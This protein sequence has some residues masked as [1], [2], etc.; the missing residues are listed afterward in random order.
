[1]KN[2]E[3]YHDYIKLLDGEYKEK[4]QEIDI[5]ISSSG[6]KVGNVEDIMNDILDLFI[7]A[8]EEN[9]PIENIIGNDI[10]EFCDQVIDSCKLTISEMILSYLDNIRYFILILAVSEAIFTFGDFVFD[11]VKN[12][13]L[14]NV[15]I[16]GSFISI[17]ISFVLFIIFCFIRKKLVFKYKW[18]SP[19]LD[20]TLTFIIMMGIIIMCFTMPD[21]VYKLIT[22]PRYIFIPVSFV[23]FIILNKRHKLIKEENNEESNE[24]HFGNEFYNEV[25]LTYRKQY[26]KYIKKCQKKNKEALDVKKWYNKKYKEDKI[27]SIIANIFIIFIIFCFIL[28]VVMTS[29]LLDGILFTV[30]VLA[31][32]IPIYYFLFRKGDRIK[33]E[34]YNVIKEKD[35]D[36]YDDNIFKDK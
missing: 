12:P 29:E 4:F 31:I 20:N 34:I 9:K 15:E 8:Q 16:G 11:E 25:I 5:Y 22:V 26:E 36:I 7:S 10:K 13:L 35:T 18:F 28:N 21:N 19:K 2:F 33:N 27:M 1:M 17:F 6:F 32:E 3:T 23:L 14:F 24:F 30:I